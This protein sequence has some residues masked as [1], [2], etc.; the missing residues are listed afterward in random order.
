MSTSSHVDAIAIRC[1]AEL[2]ALPSKKVRREA[3]RA[4]FEAVFRVQDA[5]RPWS[6]NSRLLAITR[7]ASPNRLNNCASF[8]ASGRGHHLLCCQ[9]SSANQATDGQKI[10]K[11]MFHGRERPQGCYQRS[12]SFSPLTP[13]TSFLRETRPHQFPSPPPSR[14]ARDAMECLLK[15]M[16]LPSAA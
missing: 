7:L 9:P 8:F 12:A 15:G 14:A 4:S 16:G 6:S 3:F 2:A 1:M 11:K 13:P 5:P 10:S